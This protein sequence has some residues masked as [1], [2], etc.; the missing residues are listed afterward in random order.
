MK[1]ILIRSLFALLFIL[2][3]VLVAVYFYAKSFTPSYGGELQVDGLEEQVDILYD[4]YGVPHIYGANTRD[5]HR[6]LG[7]AHAKDRLWQMDLLR[8]IAPGRLSELFGDVMI[9]N[10]KLFR[11]IGLGHQAKKEAKEF[12]QQTNQEMRD[13]VEGYILGVNDYIA[14]G[15]TTVEHK[16]IGVDMEPYTLE[17]VYNVIGYMAFSFSIAHKT[18][19]I[20]DYIKH[21]LGA[22][23]LAELDVHVA[24]G[25]ATINSFVAEDLSDLSRH[26]E[27][28]VD[29]LPAPALI[30][31]NS[32]VLG[33]DKTTTG[34][35]ILV[36]DPHIGFA[37]PSV[38]YEAHIES[39][40]MSSYGYYLAGFPFPQIGHNDHHA[41][42][43]TMLENDDIDYY[44]E[45]LD[46]SDNSRYWA[47]DQWQSLATRS[48]TIKVKG[49]EDITLE[50]RETR[51]GPIISDVVDHMEDEP[52]AMWWVYQKLPS[53]VLEASYW[54]SQGKTLDEVRRGASLIH[55]PGLNVM[56]ADV[57]G[58]IA[59][60]G[61][62]KHPIRPEHVNSKVILDGAS[63][64][65]DILGFYDFSEN[66][67]AV[68][69][70]SGYVYSANNQTV[71]PTGLRHPG[72]YL[73]PDRA[74]R[75][76]YL[77]DG[78]Q[79]WTTEEI[80]TMMGDV[81]SL[82]APEIVADILP[83]IS[84]GS[85]VEAD[86]HKILMAWKGN[87]DVDEIAPTI[88]VKLSYNLMKG[89]VEDE[90]G[91]RW[92]TFNGTHVM[93][94]S[95]QSM[96]ASTTSPWWDNTKTDQV[97]SRADMIRSAWTL[98]I[99]ELKAQ[100]GDDISQWQWGK[101]HLLTHNHAFGTLP[102]IGPMMN[103]GPFSVP[104]VS[105]VINN[106]HIKADDTG[107]YQVFAGP[108]TRR[109]VD[110]SN[111]QK[112]SWTILPTGQSGQ[113]MSPHYKDQSQLFVDQEFRRALM[114]KEEIEQ[115]QRYKMV[116]LP[117]N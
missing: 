81:T 95:V 7:Y 38:W 99:A 14:A 45:R 76:Q 52:V 84:H 61:S 42:G 88:Y 102:T 36:N 50:V 70:P 37:Q 73:P 65:D 51:H 11:T 60:W 82:N 27:D 117:V 100:W 86:A 107:I 114:L 5:V 16:L 87:Y 10:D 59:W 62:A 115:A 12:A 19:P 6:A 40:T 22:E 105:E 54:I 53:Q 106:Y 18:E 32:W 110:L 47:V 35:A 94:R 43:L 104:G 2:V 66:P 64:D 97:E 39:P 29:K 26:I 92:E 30:G 98:T 72:Y 3:V 21:R 91:E 78:Q 34:G 31:S 15:H 17:D 67:Q 8:R 46:S 109:I 13:M 48:E 68:N 111:Y 24:E 58:N 25:T 69:P 56:Y 101:A 28:L 93:K 83:E 113:V 49:G 74:R 41:I 79:V 23:Y 20:L 116:L 44:R 77:L 90:I 9:E 1:K 33:P 57:D 85:G 80:K 89:M 4:Q 108:S 63:G 96:V 112:N 103:V 71:S 55:A 75:I